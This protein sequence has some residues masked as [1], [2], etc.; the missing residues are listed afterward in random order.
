METHESDLRDRDHGEL[1]KCNKCGEILQIDR[2]HIDNRSR[3]RRASICK[4]CAIEKSRLW[5]LANP[6]RAKDQRKKNYEQNREA[7]KQRAS[8]WATKNE[9]RRAEIRRASEKKSDARNRDLV[10]MAYGGYYCVCCGENE[11]KFLAIDHIDGGGAAHRRAIGGSSN[12]YRWL[13]LHD[14]PTGFRVLCHNCNRGRYLNGGGCPQAQAHVEQ[15]RK[16]IEVE[17][18]TTITEV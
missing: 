11:P 4:L 12:F 15:R 17:Y 16:H 8:E 3:D 7:Y 5:N 10:F 2:F 18:Q 1:K 9:E 13:I 14:F 6:E